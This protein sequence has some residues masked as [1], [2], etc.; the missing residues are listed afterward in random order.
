[1][2]VRTIAGEVRRRAA[3]AIV[4]RSGLIP[5]CGALGWIYRWFCWICAL[6]YRS[7]LL[8]LAGHRGET[9]FGLEPWLPSVGL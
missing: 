6:L 1:M 3:F 2:N 5:L 7:G 8:R 4:G 9:A